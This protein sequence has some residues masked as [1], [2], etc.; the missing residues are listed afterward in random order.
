VPQAK[1]DAACARVLAMKFEAGLFE[2]PYV[3]A[4]RAKAVTNTP[5]DVKLARTVAQKSIVLLKNDG[6][7]PLDPKARLRL[8]V[9]GPNAEEPLFGGYSG[10]NDKAVGILAG[11]K[12][13]A[14]PDVT[15]E[16]AEGVRIIAPSPISEHRNAPVKLVPPGENAPRIAEAVEVAKRADVVLLVLG[17]RPEITREAVAMFAP[18]DRDTLT[19]FGDQDALV[20]AVL[21]TGKPVVALLINGR[22][23]AV[24]RLAEKAN[25]LFEGWYLGQEGGGAFADVLFGKVNPGGKLP[26]SFPRSVGQLPIFYDR[27]PSAEANQYVEGPHAPLFPF[28]H[29]LSYTAFEVSAPRLARPQIG[30]GET[31]VVEVDVANTGK[32]AGEEVVQLYIRDDVSSVPRPVLE[33]RGFQRVTLKAGERRT[34]RFELTPDA[35]AFWDIDMKW[36][37]EP[38]TFTISAGPSSAVLKSAKLTVA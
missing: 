18:G 24:N 22:A 20:E 17:D 29:G 28:G 26:V 34:V 35:L 11:V 32:R 15:V 19:L 25:A 38:G 27:H 37:V 8:A 16:Y 10:I 30:Q 36:V 1:V 21:A 12:A 3:D 9:I 6:A 14:G 4:A 5:A 33:L 7:V 13:A 2:H 23:L 31:A